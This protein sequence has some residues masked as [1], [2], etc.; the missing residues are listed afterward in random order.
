MKRNFV[1]LAILAATLPMAAAQ[2]TLN[3]S[4]ENGSSTARKATPVV[5]S[6]GNCGIAITGRSRKLRINYRTTEEIRH[7][8]TSFLAGLC[9][10]DLDGGQDA[11]EGCVSLLHGERPV[12]LT[13]S[14]DDKLHDLIAAHV[15]TLAGKG[16]AARDICITARTNQKCEHCATL[17]RDRN[18]PVYML[19]A[20]KSDNRDADGVRLATMHRVKGLEFDAVFLLDAAPAPVDEDTAHQEQALRYVAASRARKYLFLC[21]RQ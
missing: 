7:E 18:V 4:V 12:T 3:V 16:V 5:I 13:Y 9:P 8:A 17:L 2:K 19:S 14:T 15:A 1:T 6:L 21:R 11:G 10:D 20:S